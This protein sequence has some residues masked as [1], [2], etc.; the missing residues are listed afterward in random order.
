LRRKITL[1]AVLL[2]IAIGLCILGSNSAVTS[3]LIEDTFTGNGYEVRI[4]HPKIVKPNQNIVIK[5][6]G[7][8]KENYVFSGF[9][10][11]VYPCR[12]PA[13][14]K[15]AMFK[16]SIGFSPPTSEFSNT[17]RIKLSSDIGDFI[18]IYILVS[19]IKPGQQIVISYPKPII[20]NIKVERK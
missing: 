14:N 7:V 17:F 10:I 8:S 20:I 13:I 2:I 3:P 11:R 12:V 9:I 19:V 18:G 16:R 1:I 15:T 5:V 6:Y 4:L